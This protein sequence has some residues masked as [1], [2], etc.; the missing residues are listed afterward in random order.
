[1][2]PLGYE[3][4]FYIPEGAIL[5]SHCRENL[6]SYEDIYAFHTRPIHEHDGTLL[7]EKAALVKRQPL[8]CYKTVE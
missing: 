6:K 3:L 5:H 4:V 1:V 7:Y 2:S 8:S